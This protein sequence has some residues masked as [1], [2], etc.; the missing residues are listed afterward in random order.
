MRD[1]LKAKAQTLAERHGVSLSNF[2]NAPIAATVAQEEALTFFR[3]RLR[4]VDLE[5]LHQRV[6]ALMGKTREGPEPSEKELRKA[7]GD[8]F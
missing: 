7:L 3:D 1:D 8:R 4:D 6:L 2:I 5:R